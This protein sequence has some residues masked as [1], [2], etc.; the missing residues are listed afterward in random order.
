MIV[1]GKSMCCDL[2]IAS[3][4]GVVVA[5]VK[6]ALEGSIVGNDDDDKDK[7]HKCLYE[8]DMVME[9]LRSLPKWTFRTSE[10]CYDAHVWRYLGNA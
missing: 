8:K 2:R 7:K 6:S 9:A 3:P 5:I 1:S 4:A 10:R